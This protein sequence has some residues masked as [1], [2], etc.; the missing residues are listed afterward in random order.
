MQILAILLA[1]T[2]YLK[3]IKTLYEKHCGK[4]FVKT[5]IKKLSSDIY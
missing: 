1:R 2:M 5:F 4:T 3:N